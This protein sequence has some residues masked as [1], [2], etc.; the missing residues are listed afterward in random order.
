MI[1]TVLLLH[2]IPV[3]FGVLQTFMVLNKKR[4]IYRFSAKHALFIFGPF[5]P[6]RSLAIRLSVH[7]Y[8]FTK[9]RWCEKCTAPG[10]SCLSLL[11][12]TLAECCRLPCGRH[13]AG[14]WVWPLLW[15]P[16][17]QKE[18]DWGR[19]FLK[20][21]QYYEESMCRG[22]VGCIKEAPQGKGHL[23]GSLK[24]G[25]SA[26]YLCTI[27]RGWMF[28]MLW[29]HFLTWIVQMSGFSWKKN[30]TSGRARPAFLPGKNS[31][32]EKPLHLLVGACKLCFITSAPLLWAAPAHFT[33]VCDL[34]GS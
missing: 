11:P 24:Q 30:K 3:V 6:I 31:Y 1:H 9:P 5:N 14:C 17:L 32:G 21:G 29:K 2:L 15:D 10:C 16:W 20:W 26:G 22:T 8:P 34:P 27:L 18:V 13:C 33:K 25:Q 23:C 7:S 4:T 19:Q 12:Q 28:E